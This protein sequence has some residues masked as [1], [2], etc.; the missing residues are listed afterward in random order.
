MTAAVLRHLAAPPATPLA[1]CVS[2]AA[3]AGLRDLGGHVVSWFEVSGGPRVGAIGAAEGGALERAVRAAGDLGIPLVGALATSGADVTEGVASLHAWGRVARAVADVSGVVPV[4]MVV[5]GPCVSGPSLLLGMADHVVMTDHAEAYVSG[6][7]VTAA[8]TGVAVDRRALGGPH[9]HASLTGL[10]SLVVATG[11][12]GDTGDTEAAVAD[13]LSFLGPNSLADPPVVPSSDPPDRPCRRAAATVPAAATAAYDVRH[14]VEDVVDDGSFLEVRG[15]WARNVV[16]GFGRLG[17][18]SVGVVANQPSQRAG[19]IDIAASQKAARFVQSCDAF[20][21]PLVTF[22]DTPG[23]EP[24]KDLEW[25]GMIRHGAQLVH[26]YGEATVPRLCVI[27]RK[28]FGGA[29]IVMDSKGLGNDVCVAW[30]EAQVA[31]MGAPG[32]VQVLYNRRDDVLE[33][34]YAEAYLNPWVAAERGY[35]DAVIDPL[36]TRSVLVAA[37]GRLTSKRSGGPR[38]RHSNTPL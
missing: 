24:G 17:G 26:A 30:P 28:A 10:A 33:R 8:V 23:F 35:V 6:P 29:Y 38:R 4:V 1:G 11:D 37:V 32:A 19:T 27:L 16:T 5:T 12:P 20:N 15:G 18:R 34:A 9:V 2:P 21:V 36:E 7:G 14:V 3:R 22:V 31:V 13:L 25:R